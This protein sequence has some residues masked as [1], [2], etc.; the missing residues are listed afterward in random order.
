VIQECEHAD[1]EGVY[2]VKAFISLNNNVLSGYHH[3]IIDSIRHRLMKEVSL[4]LAPEKV[5]VWSIFPVITCH[6]LSSRVTYYHHVSRIVITCL[7]L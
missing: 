7:L 6:V 4:E 5:A 3:H 1:K 2:S